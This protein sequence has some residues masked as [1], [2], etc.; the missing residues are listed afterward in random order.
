MPIASNGSG[1]NVP[2]W[3][4]QIPMKEDLGLTSKLVHQPTPFG[5]LDSGNR[6]LALQYPPL[7]PALMPPNGWRLSYRTDNFQIVLHETSSL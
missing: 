2:A 5:E 6:K 3:V 1:A 7:M 4:Y